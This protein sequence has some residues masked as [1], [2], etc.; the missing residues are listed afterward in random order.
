[1]VWEGHERPEYGLRMIEPWLAH[2]H[3]KNARPEVQGAGDL[4]QL[5]WGYRWC[6]LR[7]GMVDWPAVVE[8]LRDIGYEG[9][10][11]LEDFNP[12]TQAEGKLT[13]F[14]DYFGAIFA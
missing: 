13:D 11:S 14:A 8:V 6:G 3:V 4:R 1:M 9:Y 12:D 10:L 5:E 2:V 7:E